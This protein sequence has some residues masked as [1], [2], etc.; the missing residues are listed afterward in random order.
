MMNM[1]MKA[2]AAAKGNGP[3]M[4]F[5]GLHGRERGKE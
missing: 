4:I 2:A 3:S 1:A 5:E